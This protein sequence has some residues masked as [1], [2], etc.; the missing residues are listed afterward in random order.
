MYFRNDDPIFGA[1]TSMFVICPVMAY[2]ILDLIYYKKNRSF[3]DEVIGKYGFLWQL[4]LIKLKKYWGFLERLAN[5]LLDE[6]SED[7]KH[8]DSD[9]STSKMI[10][11][12]FE[13]G[14]QFILQVSIFL[15]KSN[16]SS[17]AKV[18]TFVTNNPGSAT[19]KILTLTTSFA[20]LLIGASDVFQILPQINFHQKSLP[21]NCLKSLPSFLV[22]YPC[23]LMTISPKLLTLSLFF[24]SCQPLPG[25]ICFL[26]FVMVYVITFFSITYPMY[27]WL[28]TDEN[29]GQYRINLVK[30]FLSSVMSPCI[31]IH[32]KTNTIL[33]SS[34]ASSFSHLILLSFLIF[35]PNYLNLP[36]EQSNFDIICYTLL[37]LQIVSPIFSWI[38]NRYSK[39]ETA[40]YL[41]VKKEVTLSLETINVKIVENEPSESKEETE[42]SGANK[43]KETTE[44]TSVPTEPTEVIIDEDSANDIS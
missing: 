29:A 3:Q 28:K 35:F 2:I 34:I 25:I 37:G 22:I 15:R 21:T 23:L 38:L 44:P 19:I 16:G 31:V 36:F 27:F 1:L 33:L 24:G 10:E 42:I 9:V 39:E 43:T 32:P 13:S 14:P 20:S 18:S 7:Q 41:S 4:P 6:N 26:I 30:S 11:V 8:F 40:S 5:N 17:M 12:F